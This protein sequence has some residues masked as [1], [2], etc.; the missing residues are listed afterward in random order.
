MDGLDELVTVV[1]V[2]VAPLPLLI[3]STTVKLD[4]P[5][6]GVAAVARH[7]VVAADSQRGSAARGC[8]DIAADCE[9]HRRTTSDARAVV[10]EADAAR[11]CSAGHRGHERDAR[12]GRCRVRGADHGRRR[13]SRPAATATA[14]VGEDLIGHPFVGKPR[15]GHL[16]VFAFGGAGRV[17]MRAGPGVE[18]AIEVLAASHRS[19]HRVVHRTFIGKDRVMREH[20]ILF[21]WNDGVEVRACRRV[22]ETIDRLGASYRRLVRI[23]HDTFVVEPRIELQDLVPFC[24]IDRVE[25]RSRPLVVETDDRE[26][27][28]GICDLRRETRSEATDHRHN[29]RCTLE[30]AARARRHMILGPAEFALHHQPPDFGR[31]MSRLARSC[32]A[33]A[34][35]LQSP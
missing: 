3:I 4:V 15:P 29:R 13:R 16:D 8:S 35:R 2:A 21:V 32:G 10:G 9:S 12:A 26:G 6:S 30:P 31:W 28:V 17:E 27:R 25:V 20:V 5:L 7:D 34:P 33:H 14:R 11:R 22:E 1:V 24:A 23:E 19:A 18:K